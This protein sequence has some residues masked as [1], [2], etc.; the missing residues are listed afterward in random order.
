MN[1]K[2]NIKDIIDRSLALMLILA[3]L[4][5]F[6]I[7]LVSLFFTQG[8]N[9]FFLHERNGLGGKSFYLYKIRTLRISDTSSLDL[10]GRKFTPLGKFLR[11]SG[12]DELPQLLNIIR[13]DMSFIGPRPLPI[14]YYPKYSDLQKRRMEVKPGLTG[15]AQLHGRNAITWSHRFQ[16]DVWYVDHITWQLDI[17]IFLS[18]MAWFVHNIFDPKPSEVVMPV[19]GDSKKR[20]I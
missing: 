8:A 18:T 9:I 15:W 6:M 20:A 3:C 12:L 19:F 7:L 17:K 5:F 4:P 11:N 16:L 13:G 10:K 1:Y 2:K 14:A